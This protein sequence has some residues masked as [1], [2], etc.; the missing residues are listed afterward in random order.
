[1]FLPPTHRSRVYAE[2]EVMHQD[3]GDADISQVLRAILRQMQK[4]DLVERN[5]PVHLAFHKCL[6]LPEAMCAAFAGSCSQAQWSSMRK[7]FEKRVLQR[8]RLHG[9]KDLERLVEKWENAIRIGAT[10]YVPKID[11]TDDGACRLSAC[12]KLACVV[13]LSQHLRLEGAAQV[14]EPTWAHNLF[15]PDMSLVA[16]A[17]TIRYDERVAYSNKRPDVQVSFGTRVVACGEIKSMWA[18]ATDT[19]KDHSQVMRAAIEYMAQDAARLTLII[20]PVRLAMWCPGKDMYA[21]E[22][23]R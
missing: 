11:R 22:V 15:V 7:F 10:I 9:G 8:H 17:L 6:L 18:K 3:V 13:A 14:C 2:L 23:I 5:G 21:Y 12:P 4:K 16:M 19:L 20:Q 1:M